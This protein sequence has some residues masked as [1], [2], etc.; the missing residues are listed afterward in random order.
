MDDFIICVPLGREGRVV[1]EVLPLVAPAA[2][3]SLAGLVDLRL[4]VL[5][6]GVLGDAG[7]G[8]LVS[9][10]SSC[11]G[12]VLIALNKTQAVNLWMW[13]LSSIYIYIFFFL[14]PSFLIMKALMEIFRPASSPSVLQ[15]HLFQ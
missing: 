14:N 7:L 1:E 5:D 15:P 11:G 9:H 8:F 6:G 13:T 10:L 3:G 12:E 4:D 2:P